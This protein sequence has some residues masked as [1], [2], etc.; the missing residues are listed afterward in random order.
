MVFSAFAEKEYIWP[1]G[2]MPDPQHRQ[3]A[4]MTADSRRKGF[5]A[6]DWRNP[7]VDWFKPPQH[8]NGTCVIL[9]S[10]GSYRNLSDGAKIREWAD[11]LTE[12]GCQCVNL[13]YRTPWPDGLPMYQTAWEDAQRAVRVVRRQAD[14]RGFYPE[15]VGTMSI[16][17]GSHLALLLATSSRTPA[18]EKI[19]EVDDTPCSVDFAVAFAP[20]FVLSDGYAKP[21]TRQGDAPDITLADCFKFDPDTPPMCLLHGGSD[22]YSPL[23]S[24]M[25]YRELRKRN[26]PAEVHILPDKGHG[27][28]GFGRAVEFLRQMKFLGPLERELPLVGRY[29]Y[30]SARETHVKTPLWPYGQTPDPQP[31]QSEPYLEW[32]IPSNITTKA[33]QIIWSGGGYHRASTDDFEVAPIRRYLNEK[34]MAVVTVNY[35]HPRPELPLPKHLSALQDVQRA[36]RIVRRNA[37][38]YG[39]DPDDIGVMGA[40]AG[41]HLALIAATSAYTDSYWPIDDYDACGCD[42]QWAVALYP[43]YCLTD[44]LEK[45]NARGGNDDS[46]RLA[47]EFAFDIATPPILFM[48]GDADTWSAMNSVKA[49]E[50]LRRMG[51][52]GEL[53]TLAT[54][55]HCF[56]RT[57]SPGTG[58]YTWMDRV[59]DF[60]KNRRGVT[61]H[62]APSRI[63]HTERT[64][65][66]MSKMMIL[67][68]A[69]ASIALGGCIAYNTPPGDRRVTIAPDLGDEVVVTDI[70][71]AR[72][73]SRHYVF[74]ANLVNNTD[75]FVKLEYRVSWLG[76]NGL[77]VQS[78]ASN[79]RPK[80]LAPRE[81]VALSAVAPV[82]HACDFRFHV[83]AAR[84]ALQ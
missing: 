7:Y 40:S 57:A 15:R 56:Q 67:L 25:I 72:D 5:D 22:M 12:L 79:W 55:T 3:I 2:K 58:S 80:S 47:D 45:P 50:R 24:T 14:K 68:L 63:V 83:Q 74:Q 33:I 49:W 32:H 8:P 77:E 11:A 60:I 65:K 4:A 59:W 78:L 52:Q 37:V 9:I 23:G 21:N 38:K 62:P 53:H 36:I 61:R 84:P 35:R 29:A 82:E 66:R 31:N 46:A 6:N 18:Y 1:E 42:V 48:H 76:E 44:G 39:L 81:V 27:A 43:A 17:S 75:D 20:A 30:D 51:I 26:I 19:D 16:S 41:G 13:V 69:A 73:L 64:K 34:G 71:M 70:R 54:R 28:F 10:G